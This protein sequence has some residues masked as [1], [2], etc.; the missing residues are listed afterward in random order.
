MK[1]VINFVTAHILCLC[2]DLGD[3]SDDNFEDSNDDNNDNDSESDYYCSRVC[4]HSGHWT[5]AHHSQ[6]PQYIIQPQI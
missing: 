5:A 6:Y 3:D 1:L 2:G 4:F